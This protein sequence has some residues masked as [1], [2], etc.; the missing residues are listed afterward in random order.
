MEH[1]RELYWIWLVVILSVLI[2][3]CS[4]GGSSNTGSLNVSV[5]DAPVN[6][7][8]VEG[9]VV[10]FTGV[11]VKGPQ[12][13]STYA[14][15]DPVTGAPSRSIDLLTLSGD[16]SVVLFDQNL[17]TGKYNWMRLDTDPTKTYITVNG[18]QYALRCSSCEQNGFKLNRSFRIDDSGVVAY[19]VDFDLNKSITDPQSGDHYKLRPT[20]RVVE[21]ALAGNI[22]GTVSDTV[23]AGLGGEQGCA[24]Y[25]YGG[26]VTPD[27]IYLPE[28]GT[29]SSHVNPVSTARVAYD[30][31]TETYSYTAA[32]LPA[33]Q[34]SVALTCD[35]EFDDISEDNSITFYGPNTVTVI[36]Q[37][38]TFHNFEAASP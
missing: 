28:S 32:F 37:Q 8:E 25:V 20:A 30:S 29:P 9:V 2:V 23:I 21:T 34:Y 26:D 27:D 13:E 31:T 7:S 14:V 12:G 16:K 3:S 1:S 15:T 18:K 36:E 17:E 19:T 33:G 22:A 6:Y 10:N 5:T 4:D 24:V 11:T 35:T 38:T